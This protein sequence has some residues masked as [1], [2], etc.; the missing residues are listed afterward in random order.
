VTALRPR[1]RFVLGSWLWSGRRHN[2]EVCH[3]TLATHAS[4]SAAEC[5][6]P[7]LAWGFGR[8]PRGKGRCGGP[9]APSVPQPTTT[10][11]VFFFGVWSGLGVWHSVYPTYRRWPEGCAPDV[12]G[13]GVM[14]PEVPSAP[15]APPRRLGYCR[16][17]AGRILRELVRVSHHRGAQTCSG[18]RG[19]REGQSCQCQGK[20]EKG[21]DGS[22]SGLVGLDSSCL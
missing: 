15:S 13:W 4:D 7:R 1:D 8:M 18:R 19:R 21:F 12:P 10:S 2:V 9:L 3:S 22:G 17:A 16:R 20:M 5:S 11:L 14:P 6:P